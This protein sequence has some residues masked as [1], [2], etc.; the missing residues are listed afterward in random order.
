MSDS[1]TMG[2]EHALAAGS[3]TPTRPQGEHP[4][5]AQTMGEGANTVLADTGDGG[6]DANAAVAGGTK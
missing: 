5:F 3:R 2:M 4:A 6:R 1:R